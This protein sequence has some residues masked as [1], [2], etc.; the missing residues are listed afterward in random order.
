MC[1]LLNVDEGQL[2]FL[3]LHCVFVRAEHLA[4]LRWFVLLRH[5]VKLRVIFVL[6]I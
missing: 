4:A 3:E 2:A 1:I 6:Y 5:F